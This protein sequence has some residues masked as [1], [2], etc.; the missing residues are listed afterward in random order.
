MLQRS[1]YVCARERLASLL[2]RMLMRVLSMT[3]T[4]GGGED[5]LFS[6]RPR[7]WRGKPRT[8]GEP[9][10]NRRGEERSPR[11][12]LQGCVSFSSEFIG[13]NLDSLEGKAWERAQASAEHCLTKSLSPPLPSVLLQDSSLKTAPPPPPPTH[14][15]QA[16]RL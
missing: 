16:C 6:A 14:T 10:E 15:K 2:H 13:E 11:N 4:G 8:G 9:P 12:P 1:V 7:L 5:H 3:K